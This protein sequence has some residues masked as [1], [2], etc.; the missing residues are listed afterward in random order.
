MFLG[1]VS[2]SVYLYIIIPKGFFPPQD[3]GIVLGITE[4]AQDISFKDMMNV[5]QRLADIVA[6]DPDTAAYRLLDG[7]RV[8]RAR[9]T[10]R[11]ACSSR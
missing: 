9:P 8:W 5:Q 1:T 2:L 10:T 4:A 7:R 6:E 3:N 11:G